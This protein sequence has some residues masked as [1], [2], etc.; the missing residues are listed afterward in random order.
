MTRAPLSCALVSLFA[1]A[2]LL[3]FGAWTTLGAQEAPLAPGAP[4]TFESAD[5][6]EDDAAPDGEEAPLT[7][8]GT[9]LARATEM[10][11][12]LP[13]GRDA[14]DERLLECESLFDEILREHPTAPETYVALYQRSECQRLLSRFEEARDGFAKLADRAAPEDELDPWPPR[15]AFRR[16]E[17]LRQLDE[18]AAAVEQYAV[19]HQEHRD[20]NLVPAAMYF[21]GICLRDLGQFDNARKVWGDL[22]GRHP[23][24]RYTQTARS[25]YA[26]LVPPI[27]RLK[28]LVAAYEK[29]KARYEKAPFQE[30]RTVLRDVEKSLERIGE[31]RS[32]Q[33]ERL[34]LD[35]FRKAK[36]D[37]QSAVVE[38][39][40]AAG[41]PRAAKVL[42]DGLELLPLVTQQRVL[43]RIQR[44][45]MR[46]NSVDPVGPIV[47]RRGQPRLALAAVNLLGR[48]G[49]PEAARLLLA[50]ITDAK[51]EDSLDPASR[52]KN[53]LI[54]RMLRRLSSQDAWQVV[55]DE[56]L[57]AKRAPLLARRIVAEALG[58]SRYP[59]A[60]RC[61]GELL[62][63]PD[64]ALAAAC[65][66]SLG[67][68]R[69]QDSAEAILRQLQKRRRDTDYVLAAV[70]ALG[71]VDP[72]V[73][74]AD[75]I[76]LMR[77]KNVAIRT[78]SVRALGKI[79]SGTARG[80]VIEALS[81][82][83]WQVRRAAL[84]GC[85][86]YPSKALIA[87]LIERMK[88][89]DGALLPMVVR[90]LITFTGVDLGP[91]VVE[92]EKYWGFEK[93]RWD[94]AR[95]AGLTKK[96]KAGKNSGTFVK[97]ADAKNADSPSYFGVE[98]ISKRIA[99]VVD[100]SGSM[101][102]RVRVPK[103][104]GGTSESTKIDLAKSELIGAINKLRKG[105][106]FNIV[107]FSGNFTSMRPK[108]VKLSRKS[109]K[110]AVG[111]AQ[112]LGAG[113]GTNIFDSLEFVLKNGDIDTVFLLSDGAPSAGKY[114]DAPRI[115]EEIERIN[116]TS[117]VTIHT[118]AVGFDSELMRR[119]AEQNDGNYIVVG[120]R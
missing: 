115:L 46:G 38:P 33:T 75:L 100:V 69:A 34:L 104:G 84:Q 87:A 44:R 15:I 92:W 96:K 11:S 101:S 58:Y 67:R 45:Q 52:Q 55:V 17:C 105:T 98:I 85:E 99:F 12:E 95:I 120:T 72:T 61:L 70:E 6:E 56:S 39:L 97:K 81:D 91:Q 60:E 74:E 21:A 71:R 80:H 16:A 47:T 82:R 10:L 66:T 32:E 9:R 103:E 23:S 42:L 40:L 83:A 24:D 30:K 50:G 62:S 25:D 5:E 89:E 27:E 68:L 37:L 93:E 117:Q 119:I 107:K 31:V 2:L 3:A 28:P 48:I 53:G 19:V 43:D 14:R 111:F 36:G 49:T 114:T 64:S 113:G 110:Q 109:H 108:L 8:A 112:G 41:G 51:N 73:A 77:H 116:A 90:L 7:E 13:R 94:P 35:Q 88:K 76:A 20:S 54:A 78:L 22:E 118:I 102:G 106:W 65:T 4:L 26:T 86:P 1:L 79:D 18:W 57:L 63:H 29:E 59:D